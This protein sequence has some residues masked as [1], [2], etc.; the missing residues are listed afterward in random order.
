MDYVTNTLSSIVG[1]TPSSSKPGTTGLTEDLAGLNL[2]GGL[3]LSPS[4]VSSFPLSSSASF[5]QLS[6]TPR[7][8]LL[9]SVSGGGLEVEYSFLRRGSVH[10]PQ[11]NTIL[12][13]FKNQSDRPISNIKIGKT[14]CGSPR[15]MGTSLTGCQNLGPGMAL[16]P[17]V[18][19][20][21]LTAGA[22]TEQS[23]SVTFV[24]ATQP[25][26]FELSYVLPPPS[27]SIY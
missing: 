3:S 12:L 13:Y 26:K 5:T 27:I 21:E 10:G 25:A 20:K 19:I 18:E 23:I 24:N 16:I 7:K 6:A 9:K 8:T 22:S 15:V 2:S 1:F 17:F 4:R 14:V 11:V